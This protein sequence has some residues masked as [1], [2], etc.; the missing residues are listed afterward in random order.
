[1]GV[2]GKALGSL[3]GKAIGG[4][5]G[6]AFGHATGL[7]EQKGSQLGEDIGGGIGNLIPFKKGGKVKK[8]GPILAHKGEFILPKG[9]KPTAK[10][11]KAVKKRRPRKTKKRRSKK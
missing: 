3:A 9:V 8:T 6:K 2:I 7:G 10:Q 4:L 1:M 5:A 11:L